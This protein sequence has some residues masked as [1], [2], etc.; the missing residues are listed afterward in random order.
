MFKQKS[1]EFLSGLPFGRLKYILMNQEEKY[2]LVI[3]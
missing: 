2:C 1:V 3:E